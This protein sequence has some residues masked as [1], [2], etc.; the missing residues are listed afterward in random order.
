MSPTPADHLN[1]FRRTLDGLQ[2]KLGAP[3]QDRRKN[4]NRWPFIPAE[5]QNSPNLQNS[6]WTETK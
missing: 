3:L 5:R 6:L 2:E 1:L 4:K